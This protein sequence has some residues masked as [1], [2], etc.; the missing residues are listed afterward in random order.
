M[1]CPLHQNIAAR[2]VGTSIQ[3]PSALPKVSNAIHAEAIIIT[4]CCASQ[5]DTARTPGSEEAISHNATLAVIVD[6]IPATPHIGTAAE[7]IACLV[8]PGPLPAVL[9][10]VPPITHH[11]S[12]PLVPKG[13][14]HPTGSTRMPLR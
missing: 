7:T 6:I 1:H 8:I 14:Q 13:A 3:T 10:I 12:T 9:H 4:L 2:S 11:P 5:R